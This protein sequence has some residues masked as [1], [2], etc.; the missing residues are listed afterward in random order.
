[1][2][3]LVSTS[4]GQG[5]DEKQRDSQVDKLLKSIAEGADFEFDTAPYIPDFIAIVGGNNQLNLDL[6]IRALQHLKL[7]ANPEISVLCSKFR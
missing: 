4:H 1:M 7:K 5:I 3:S 6:A 2:L